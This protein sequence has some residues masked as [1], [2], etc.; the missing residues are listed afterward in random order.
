MSLQPS[1]RIH[2]ADPLGL[3]DTPFIVTTAYAGPDGQPRSEWFLVIPEDKGQ[4][5]SQRSM[6]ALES[7][8]DSRA[9]FDAELLL[10]EALERA[11]LRLRRYIL[12]TK[13]AAAQPLLA[14]PT[15][16][17]AADYTHLVKLWLRGAYCGCL[18]E[19]RAKSGCTP[20]IDTLVWIHGL[21]MLASNDL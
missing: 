7:F 1:Y 6:L 4:L 16:V 2:L 19:I 9:A 17:Q 3:V 10:S 5:F 13:G 20:L 11:G 15:A 12:E 8:P 21:P 18:S 14:T